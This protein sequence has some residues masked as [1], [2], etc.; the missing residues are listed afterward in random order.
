MAATRNKFMQSEFCVD[1]YQVVRQKD[2][3]MN[4]VSVVNDRPAMPI[5]ANVPRMPASV[6]ANNAVD[7]ESSLYGIGANNFIYPKKKVMPQLVHLPDVSFYTAPALYLP[8]LPEVRGNE[9]PTNF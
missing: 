7:I 1:R 6:F 9:R 3:L 8:I 4:T 5:G 2:W